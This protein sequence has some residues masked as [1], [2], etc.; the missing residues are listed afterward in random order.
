[1]LDSY[2]HGIYCRLGIK[3]GVNWLVDAM[4]RSKRTEMLRLRAGT[5]VV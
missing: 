5:N 1:M 3:E 2:S 4:E